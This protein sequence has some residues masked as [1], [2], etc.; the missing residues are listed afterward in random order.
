MKYAATKM[1][2]SSRLSR[3]SLG[4]GG[5]VPGS[6]VLRFLN[7]SRTP[8]MALSFLRVRS[9]AGFVRFPGH[10]SLDREVHAELREPSSVDFGRLDLD[11]LRRGR[12]VVNDRRALQIAHQCRDACVRLRI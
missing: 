5:H 8:V 4:S 12:R 3:T 9:L 2:T 1:P 7:W 6:R 11:E 10:R